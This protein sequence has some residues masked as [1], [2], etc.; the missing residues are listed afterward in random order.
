MRRIGGVLAVAAGLLLAG[1]ARAQL[2]LDV[3][4]G[5]AMPVG[6]LAKF[7]EPH[8]TGSLKN[9]VS[10][11]VPLEL[12]ARWRFSPNFSAGI[13]G[14]YDPAF[15]AS[16]FCTTVMTCSGSDSRLGVEA[17]YA[18]LPD[19]TFNPWVS[20][21]TGWEWTHFDVTSGASNVNLT[22]SGWEYFNVQVGVDWNVSRTFAFGPYVG[23]FG[24]SYSARS[25]TNTF[26]QGGTPV[27]ED[28]TG[29]IDSSYR[30]F[31]GWLQFGLKGTV[32]L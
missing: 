24:G 7:G 21:G 9:Y 3:K 32:N 31:H 30:A 16:R 22:Y 11:A 18:F 13:Y 25:G 2:S 23:F 26:V 29:A 17:V 20:L 6:E 8:Y 27:T 19:R 10:G 12:A 1:P 4:A 28:W 14:Q 15:V 5:Y